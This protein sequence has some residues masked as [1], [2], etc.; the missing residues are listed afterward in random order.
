MKISRILQDETQDWRASARRIAPWLDVYSLHGAQG[1]RLLKRYHDLPWIWLRGNAEPIPWMESERRT[2]KALRVPGTAMENTLP[3]DEELWV[4]LPPQ[5]EKAIWQGDPDNLGQWA[6]NALSSLAQLPSICDG[7]RPEYTICAF[8]TALNLAQEAPERWRLP[9]LNAL[10]KA[11]ILWRRMRIQP[12]QQIFLPT[13]GAPFLWDGR[14]I[15]PSDASLCGIGY[16]AMT[17]AA[18]LAAQPTPESAARLMQGYTE[19]SGRV[20]LL[21]L[22]VGMLL[23]ELRLS[24]LHPETALEDVYNRY[25]IPLLENRLPDNPVIL[26]CYS[27]LAGGF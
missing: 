3:L 15:V 17:L 21:S 20:P 26:A 7:T 2:A 1:D 19:S 14:G 24:M 16:P 9:C 25:A 5:G 8:Q 18:M 10:D 4:L 6:A 13:E 22:L 11:A 12:E 27:Y 23:N